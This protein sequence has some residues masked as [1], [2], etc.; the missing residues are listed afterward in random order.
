MVLNRIQVDAREKQTTLVINQDLRITEGIFT[1]NLTHPHKTNSDI[2][3]S[4]CQVIKY[5][6]CFY[7]LWDVVCR[8][9]MCYFYKKMVTL[10]KL[11]LLKYIF[12]QF[13][14]ILLNFLICSIVSYDFITSL[15]MTSLTEGGHLDLFV[16]LYQDQ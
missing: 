1:Q 7:D 12:N 15:V 6:Y 13:V 8:I 2:Q 11:F 9:N 3:Q 14:H 16:S 4:P 5:L 10:I